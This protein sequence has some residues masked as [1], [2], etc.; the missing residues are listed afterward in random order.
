MNTQYALLN[1]TIQEN[2]TKKLH[3]LMYLIIFLM[4]LQLGSF[5]TFCFL[6]FRNVSPIAEFLD[7][8]KSTFGD[9]TTGI[10]SLQHCFQSSGLC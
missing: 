6:L 5:V 7:A 4:I 1:Q 8:A 3:Q 10:Q 9:L 2:K